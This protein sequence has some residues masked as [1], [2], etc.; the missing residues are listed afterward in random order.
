MSASQLLR[1]SGASLALGTLLGLISIIAGGLL[2]PE[3]NNPSY[4]THP[5]YVPLNL[6]MTVG[7]ALLLLG[8]PG[9]YT[10]QATYSGT[11]G[12]IGMVLIFI[13]LLLFGIF[14]SLLSALIFPFVAAQAP[15]LIQA[16]GP[17]GLFPL[18]I[19]G[20]VVSTLGPILFAV[21]MFRS[22]AQPRWAGYVLV[23]AGLFSLASLT[24]GPG[25]SPSVLT[26]AVNNASPVLLFI[27]L[28]WL[29]WQLSAKARVPPP[30]LE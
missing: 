12:L 28:G 14:F 8:L 20:T 22:S 27:A 18:F 7:V 26:T 30:P 21:P 15:Q 24:S 29:G 11:V 19:L 5:L 10:S 13:F 16:E 25:T 4:G 9:L 1:L 23:L 6:L 2:F 17:P 3:F